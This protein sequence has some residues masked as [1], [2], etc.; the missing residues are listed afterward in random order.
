[1]DAHVARYLLSFNFEPGDIE[2]MN[3]LGERAREGTLSPEEA[4]EIDSYLHVG[5][6][7]TVMQSKARNWLRG[8]DES[9]SRA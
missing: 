5:N 7:L 4:G 2:R 8:Q 3:F 9:P 6:L 1:M